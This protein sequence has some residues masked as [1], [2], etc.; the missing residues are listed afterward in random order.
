MPESVAHSVLEVDKV[1]V[2]EAQQVPRVEVQVA[3][4]QHV[5]EPLLLRLLLVAGVADERGPVGDS[6]HQESRL[7]WCAQ[8]DKKQKQ[9]QIFIPLEFNVWAA[10]TLHS[11][12]PL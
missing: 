6:P 2:I 5:T 12:L 4:P 7:A 8:K 10:E 11:L 1:L 9:K 3:L